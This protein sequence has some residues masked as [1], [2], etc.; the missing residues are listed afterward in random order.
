MELKQVVILSE[1]FKKFIQSGNYELSILNIM[2]QSQLIFPNVYER[3]T[4][5][6]NNE[7]DFYDTVSLEKYEAK[8][9]FDKKEGKLICSNL[10]SFKEWLSFMMNEEAEFG[11]LIIEKRGQ[12]KITDLKLYNT[13]CKRLKSV[14]QN[15]NA[16]ILFPYPITLDIE[17]Q[18]ELSMLQFCSDILSSVFSELKRNKIIGKRMVYAIYPSMDEKI[19]LR[20]LNNNMRE[21][22]KTNEFDPF[23]KYSFSLL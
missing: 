17:P 12:Y 1:E 6:S 23:F 5:Q 14:Q 19:V 15:E 2:N 20:C 9:P 22:L 18:S 11:E 13:L 10:G 8:L 7:C 3:N 21:Y 4:V 16:I